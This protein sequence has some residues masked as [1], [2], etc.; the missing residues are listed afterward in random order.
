MTRAS[1]LLIAAALICMAIS[2]C[3]TQ[4][5]SP[6]Q[7]EVIIQYLQTHPYQMPQAQYYPMQIPAPVQTQ[8]WRTGNT[9]SCTS[10]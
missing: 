5:L 2:G 4:S 9:M 10:Y 8:C 3:T 6:E 7:R 1:R